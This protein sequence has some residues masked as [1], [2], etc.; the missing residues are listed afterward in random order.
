MQSMELFVFK[1]NLEKLKQLLF[2]DFHP[3]QISMGSGPGIIASVC[4]LLLWD[5]VIFPKY[6]QSVRLLICLCWKIYF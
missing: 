3:G 4:Y 6:M 1:K 5:T 2:P